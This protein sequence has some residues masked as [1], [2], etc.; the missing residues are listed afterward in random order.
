MIEAGTKKCGVGNGDPNLR[1][2]PRLPGSVVG[3]PSMRHGAGRGQDYEGHC[4]LVTKNGTQRCQSN[5]PFKFLR[6][7]FDRLQP[8]LQPGENEIRD[9]GKNRRQQS[10]Q[11][12][13]AKAHDLQP[14]I[15][16]QFSWLGI[17]DVTQ[18]C[19][20][21]HLCIHVKNDPSQHI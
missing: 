21:M 20:P 15:P 17:S 4:P 16:S 1:S 8:R 12:G 5:S 13:D 3:E 6:L 19:I 9:S 10:Q 18:R 2:Q 7:S 14:E 11:R